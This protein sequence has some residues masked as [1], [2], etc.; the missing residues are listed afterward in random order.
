SPCAA[1][2]PYTT[3]FRSTEHRRDPFAAREARAA[4]TQDVLQARG[5]Y[6][7]RHRE[8]E[9]DPEQLAE[10]RGVVAGVPGVVVGGVVVCAV[11]V[12]RS[13]EHTSELQSRENL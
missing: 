2:A 6:E 5:E 9:A 1:P 4:E 8:H 11:V 10:L 7:R 13:E 12:G 3:L